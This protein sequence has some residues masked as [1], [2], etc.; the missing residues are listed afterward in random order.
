MRLSEAHRPHNRLVFRIQIEKIKIDKALM[1][2]MRLVLP[3]VSL[4]LIV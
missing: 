1:E 3:P 2:K 4:S